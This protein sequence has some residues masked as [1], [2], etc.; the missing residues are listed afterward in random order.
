MN[1]KTDANYAYK[2][3]TSWG[4]TDT[5]TDIL[6][7]KRKCK[8]RSKFW[9]LTK[10]CNSH[11]VSHFAAFFIVVGAKTSVAE[12]VLRY[13]IFPSELRTALPSTMSSRSRSFCHHTSRKWIIKGGQAAVLK[14]GLPKVCVKVHGSYHT[15]FSR[16]R[17]KQ[18]GWGVVMILPQVHLRKPCYDFTFL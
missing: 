5:P 3:N 13:F 1:Y 10:F 15:R 16:K 17:N 12:S 4:W 9:W 14:C 18:V 6:P 8:M 7:R 2:K 11:D